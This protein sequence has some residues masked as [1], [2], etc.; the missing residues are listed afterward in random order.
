MS[1]GE[2][3]LP[4]PR[5]SPKGNTESDGQ[6][7]HD[8]TVRFEKR[9]RSATHAAEPQEACALLHP[10]QGASFLSTPL[11]GGILKPP[12]LRVVV[13]SRVHATRG[14]AG[15]GLPGVGRAAEHACTSLQ[16]RQLHSLSRQAK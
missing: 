4:K 2:V 10:L 1:Y 11:Q 9:G 13:D 14:K 6:A 5:K 15:R 16:L 8:I 7:A 12:A 3:P